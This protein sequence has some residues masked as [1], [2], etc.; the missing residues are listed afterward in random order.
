MIWNPLIARGL[1][2][3]LADPNSARR[4]GT[5]VIQALTVFRDIDGFKAAIAHGRQ[6]PD[7]RSLLP[8]AQTYSPSS[9][10]RQVSGY[11]R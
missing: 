10:N 2:I 1:D 11:L 4:P 8:Q 7:G 6:L 3:K 9:A 5:A